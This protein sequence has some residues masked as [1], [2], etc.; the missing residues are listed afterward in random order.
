MPM[1][2]SECN[3]Q[4]PHIYCPTYMYSH[5]NYIFLGIMLLVCTLMA[6]WGHVSCACG[7]PWC[8][9]CFV[10]IISLVLKRKYRVELIHDPW[11]WVCNFPWLARRLAS[12][13]T[14]CDVHNVASQP[15]HITEHMDL[16]W[17]YQVTLYHWWQNCCLG[18]RMHDRCGSGT[19]SGFLLALV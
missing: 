13:C 4:R 16:L 3:S 11:N 8:I 9:I 19:Q 17:G 10:T 14:C 6:Q 7:M 15:C 18:D 1:W 5:R 2:H 12:L